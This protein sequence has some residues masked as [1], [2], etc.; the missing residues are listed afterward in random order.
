MR[1]RWR[2]PACPPSV[3][4]AAVESGV[5]VVAIGDS[6]Q[7]S[8]VQAGGWFGHLT[9]RFGAHRLEDV[10]RQ[11]DPQERAMLAEIH[12]GNPRPYIEFKQERGELLTFDG[13]L[14]GLRA[15]QQAV[16]MLLEAR[17]NPEIGAEH[18]IV[19]SLENER[20]H[21]INDIV[22][23]ALY[24]DGE[25]GETVVIGGREWAVGDRVITR[26][27]DREID[28]DNGMRGTI[29][30]V[31]EDGIQVQIDDYQLVTLPAWY[32]AEH[33]QHAYAITGHSA[34]GATV[35]WATVIGRP[36][37]FTK[38]WAY[39]ALSRAQ[40]PTHMLVIDEPTPSQLERA[41]TGPL[42]TT[43]TDLLTRLEYRMKQ[44]DDE[45]LAISQIDAAESRRLWEDD[46]LAGCEAACRS[47]PTAPVNA[48]SSSRRAQR[49]RS[50]RGSAQ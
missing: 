9:D 44:R 1:R 3:I 11:I 15:T 31:S 6:G 48:R 24:A 27:N 26:R 18:A 19:I 22:R 16:E 50:H 37:D 40:L 17:R 32:V 35:R 8:S 41:E 21:L 42:E 47:P 5:K 46:A 43:N 45:D 49:M 39:T 14:A 33:T 30:T 25:L 36:G 10:R 29:K 20:R 34:Q 4:T 12:A 38:N 28:V 23:E 2:T 13:D 7:L